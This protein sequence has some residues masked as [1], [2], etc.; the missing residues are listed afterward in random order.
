MEEVLI[1]AC[2]GGRLED[3]GLATQIIEEDTCKSVDE[4]GITLYFKTYP[5]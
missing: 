5:W 4:D 1:G 3:I 2:A